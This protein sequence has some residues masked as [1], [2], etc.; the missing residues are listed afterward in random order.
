[1]GH[2]IQPARYARQG[3]SKKP[4]RHPRSFVLSRI[5]QQAQCVAGYIATD[6]LGDGLIGP[7]A[8]LAQSASGN[9][10]P[11]IVT[12]QEGLS[13]KTTN[14][15]RSEWS[16]T[17]ANFSFSATLSFS[18]IARFFLHSTP[19]ANDAQ[20]AAYGNSGSA[21]CAFLSFTTGGLAR[22]EWRSGGGAPS[23]PATGSTDWRSQ[24]VT[25]GCS[26]NS[27]KNATLYENGVNITT[28]TGGAGS[29]T[30]GTSTILEFSRFEDS[31]GANC[32]VQILWAFCF[33]KPPSDAEHFE[34]A[35]R[36][37][38]LIEPKHRIFG[39]TPPTVI[40]AAAAQR[41]QPINFVGQ[42]MRR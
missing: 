8:V 10:P 23:G 30:S 22:A 33:N 2:V 3:Q 35:V 37:W 13:L 7:D 17:V 19:G 16:A 31:I 25:L 6:N 32:P 5:A 18:I 9:T 20:A 4:F 40:S 14:G 41:F 36:P 42:M 24:F 38:Q 1:M 34:F 29:D 15:F 21:G 12:S 28:G 11:T 39:K 26:I 27:S